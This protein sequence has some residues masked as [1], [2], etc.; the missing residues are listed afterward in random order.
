MSPIGRRHKAGVDRTAAVLFRGVGDAAI[1]RVQSSIVL[2]ER[3][4]PEPD[5]ALLRPRDDFYAD[6]DETPEDV[7]L[8]VEVADSSEVYDRRTKAPLYARHGIP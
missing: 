6:A 1:V 3:S 2:G 4:E 8:V 7:L 5:V